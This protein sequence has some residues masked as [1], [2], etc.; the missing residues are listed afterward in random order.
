MPALE[1]RLSV[2]SSM[3]SWREKRLLN[4]DDNLQPLCWTYGTGELIDELARI[5]EILNLSEILQ[6]PTEV[7]DHFGIST[8]F[9]ESFI[10]SHEMLVMLRD[11]VP[12]YWNKNGQQDMQKLHNAD[13]VDIH[14]NA[15]ML[16]SYKHANNCACALSL[17]CLCKYCVCVCSL[18]LP[19]LPLSKY[20]ACVLSLSCLC[21]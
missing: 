8:C 15:L 4:Q 19:S 20:C 2:L 11:R 1:G 3:V 5:D 12:S 13:S 10:D 18:S 6:Q 9:E 21:K 16:A 17:S 14:W 7:A